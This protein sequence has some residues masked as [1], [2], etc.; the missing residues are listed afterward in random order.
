MFHRRRRLRYT[1]VLAACVSA[2]VLPRLPVRAQDQ[3]APRP[4]L[5]ALGVPVGQLPQAGALLQAELD[6]IKAAGEPLTVGEM[7]LP[8]VPEDENAALVYQQAFDL[9]RDTEL[10]PPPSPLPVHPPPGEVG[11]GGPAPADTPA[12]P[13]GAYAP[14]AAAD[15]QYVADNAVA[16]ALL[17]KAAAMPQCRWPQDWSATQPGTLYRQVRQCALLLAAKMRVEARAGHPD[18]SLRTCAVALAL[19]RLL[20][21]EPRLSGPLEGYAVNDVT[22][23]GL[24]SSLGLEFMTIAGPLGPAAPNL[25]LPS[26]AA[27]RELYAQLA[28]VEL[29]AP[30]HRAMLGERARAIEIY[31]SIRELPEPAAP[32]WT[33]PQG[34]EAFNWPA[35]WTTPSGEQVLALDEVA[36]LQAMAE[37]IGEADLPWREGR[38]SLTQTDALVAG[39]PEYC[40]VTKELWMIFGRAVQGRDTALACVARTQMALAL[41]AYHNGTGRWPGRLDWLRWII[42]WDLPADPFT[43]GGFAYMREGAG[44][45]VLY[46]VGPDLQNDGGE[47]LP[48]AEDAYGAP[49]ADLVWRRR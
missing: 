35:L 2:L 22:F 5:Q 31:Q 25:P 28:G 32:G 48:G 1:L 37:E 20:D 30:F 49:A 27:C 16:V 33:A 18:D 39:L 42:N 34:F 15:Q 45:W 23:D 38:D 29:A 6:K 12:P 17:E 43:G 44:G 4:D 26:T 13:A 47:G 46:S 11:A 24:R 40:L 9:L 19:P 10:A 21:Q 8:P 41:I 14:L 3:Q 36:Y 7:A